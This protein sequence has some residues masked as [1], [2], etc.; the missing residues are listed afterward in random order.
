MTAP[1]DVHPPAK[2]VA[3][4]LV[5]ARALAPQKAASSGFSPPL[6]NATHTLVAVMMFAG[7]VHVGIPRGNEPWNSTDCGPPV[8][9][10]QAANAA[11]DSSIVI[12]F[13]S[14]VFSATAADA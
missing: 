2:P 7:S 4:T 12:V 13:E 14:P 5:L 10:A 1:P 8:V 3:G 11:D 9:E 6:Q